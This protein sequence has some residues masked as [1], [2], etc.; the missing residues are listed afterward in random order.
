MQNKKPEFNPM[1]MLAQEALIARG[2][3]LGKWGADGYFGNVSQIAYDQF[4]EDINYQTPKTTKF[5][6]DNKRALEEYYGKPNIEKRLSPPNSEVYIVPPYP[7]VAAWNENIKINKI[8]IHKRLK[9]SF[10]SILNTVVTRLGIE[11]IRKHGLHKFGGVKS[12]RY[13]FGGDEP[14]THAYL[15]AVDF[16]TADNA[17]EL[18]WINGKQGQKGY[19]TMPMEFIEIFIEHGWVSA[20]YDWGYDAMHFQATRRM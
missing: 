18:P 11:F 9:E 10:L 12:I 16:N 14:S 8:V 20:A 4:L 7:M 2:K 3:D 13:K 15:A 17:Y 1:H 5:P 19:A 6:P